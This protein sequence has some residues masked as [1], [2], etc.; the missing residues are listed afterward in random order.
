MAAPLSC[1]LMEC[2]KAIEGGR[3]DVA[4]SLLAVIQSLAP[5]EE[6]TWRRK[7][8]K[9]FAEALVR[10]AYGIRPPCALPSLPAQLD[11]GDCICGPFYDFATITS[12]HY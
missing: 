7:V 2:A 3:L 12:K 11:P 9:Y 8:V 4:D 5:K 10:R 6:S 1:I